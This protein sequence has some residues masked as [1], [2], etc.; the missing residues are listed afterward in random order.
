MTVAHER[1]IAAFPGLNRRVGFT[2]LGA[3]YLARI[4]KHRAAQGLAG[5]LS[6]SS[7]DVLLQPT[8]ARRVL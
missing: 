6:E 2:D 3:D 1:F 8:L 7:Y 5:R 4:N